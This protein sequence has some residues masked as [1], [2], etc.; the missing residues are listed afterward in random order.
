MAHNYTL[1]GAFIRE[2]PVDKIE[3]VKNLTAFL[4]AS[5]N[6]TMIARKPFNPILG[7]TYQAV[8]DDME[9]YF[10]QT[11]HHPPVFNYLVLGKGFRIHGF[12]EIVATGSA[13]SIEASTLGDSIFEF[14]DGTVIRLKNGK[15]TVN[16]VLFGRRTFLIHDWFGVEDTTNSISCLFEVHPT[17]SD[18]FFGKLFSSKDK[19]FPDYFEG[20][21]ASTE[22][23]QKDKK[24]FSV[25]NGKVLSKV[26]GEMFGSCCFDDVVYWRNGEVKLA[27]EKPMEFTL[28]SDS[29]WREDVVLFKYGKEEMAQFA[30]MTLEDL[31]RKDAKLREKYSKSGNKI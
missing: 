21:I 18:G 7:E 27:K 17:K 3:R 28:P 22:D 20:F 9:L 15:V 30:K 2:G 4:V 25:R 5:I 16:G 31:Q 13:N 19:R 1:L 6:L 8:I 12:R 10:E 14:D 23:I 29:R 11:S 24:G 26:T